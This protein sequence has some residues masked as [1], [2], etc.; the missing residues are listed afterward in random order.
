MRLFSHATHLL[1]YET[2]LC[3][4]IYRSSIHL[5]YAHPDLK[6]EVWYMS[7]LLEKTP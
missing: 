1:S 7:L 4:C 6:G 5:S 2:T 3:V